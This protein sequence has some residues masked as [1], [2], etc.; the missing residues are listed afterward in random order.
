MDGTIWRDEE[1]DRRFSS[2]AWCS[3]EDKLL[4]GSCDGAEPGLGWGMFNN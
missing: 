2:G 1:R 3:G 4:N